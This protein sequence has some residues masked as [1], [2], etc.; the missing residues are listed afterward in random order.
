M[1]Y[2]RDDEELINSQEEIMIKEFIDGWT[3]KNEV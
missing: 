1:E 2:K 3:N